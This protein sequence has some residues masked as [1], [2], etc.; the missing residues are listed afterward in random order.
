[1]EQQFNKINKVEGTLSLPGDK[2]ISHRSVIFSS[3]A[4][5]ESVIHN[6]G[7]GED[8]KSTVRC[9]SSM[10][11][12]FANQ[13]DSLIVKGLG[14][15]KLK[16]PSSPLNAGNSGTTARLISGVL[17]N[18]D[19]DS[20]IIGDESLSRRPMQRVISP[21][22]L[23]GA[24]IHAS[25]SGTLPVKVFGSDKLNAIEYEIPVASAQVKSCIILSGLHLQNETK[26]IEGIP[27]RDHT[28]K[29]LG[30]T[31]S[32]SIGKKIIYV[33]NKNYP[34]PTVY[35]V[36]GDI[37]TAAFF[38]PLAL[39]TDNSELLI[40]NVSL[41]ETRIGVVTLLKSMG[42]NIET[43]NI[44][45]YNGELSGDL[46][47]KTSHLHNIEIPSEIIPNII[48]EIPILAI[49]GILSSGRFS[50]RNAKELRGKESDRIS[51]ICSNLLHLGLNV[52][53]FP[54][55]FEFDG[56]ITNPFPVF[57]SYED[58]RIAMS[59]GILSLL[60]QNGG[61]VNNFNSV[62]ISNPDFIKQLKTISR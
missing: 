46:I 33:S 53:E 3:L 59:F 39:L 60:L 57:E 20:E 18:Q 7:N 23:M 29:M 11:V 37:S 61:K 21:L 49:A 56:Q 55:G 22:A 58:H 31:V 14:L 52:T 48:D 15:K 28:E 17:V 24:N 8:V 62:A 4:E 26:L 13:H 2:S 19:F 5:G 25:P 45:Q 12:N 43:E 36:P 40:K 35:H 16:K 32:N 27:S 34:V 42:G 47:I 51:S 6:L 38:M 54:D 10:G 9:F 41:N 44:K 1:M 30:L 50:I